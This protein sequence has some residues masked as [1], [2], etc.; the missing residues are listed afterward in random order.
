VEEVS[1]CSTLCE[2][3]LAGCLAC[4]VLCAICSSIPRLGPPTH[5]RPRPGVPRKSRIDNLTSEL[6]A[7]GPLLSALAKPL[8]VVDETF[9]P[10]LGHALLDA[11]ADDYLDGERLDAR[12]L[13]FSLEKAVLRHGRHRKPA[14]ISPE[15]LASLSHCERE[16]LQLFMAGLSVKG[17][18]RRLGKN[19]DTVG[20]QL[21]RARQKLHIRSNQQ[22]LLLSTAA[23]PPIG[24]TENRNCIAGNAR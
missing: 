3:L 11:G 16:V 6:S 21:A 12:E 14:A 24:H 7:L 23:T 22:L 8:V 2:R 20:K 19:V 18:A 4:V 5:A 9:D 1:S 13:Q 15:C 10:E 17:I